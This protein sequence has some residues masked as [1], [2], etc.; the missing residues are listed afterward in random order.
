MKT[1]WIG[2]A[3]FKVE[4]NGYSVVIDPYKP[5]SVPGL[6]AINETADAVLLSHHHGDHDGAEC[7]K[8]VKSGAPEMKVT[9]L[10][11]YHDHHKGSKRGLN[12]M[13]ILEIDGIKVAHLGDL[14]CALTEEEAKALSG[15]DLLMI[16]VG[17][18]FTIDAAEAAGIVKQLAP[19]HVIPMHF[20][21]DA[22]GIGYDVIGPVEEFTKQF[23]KVAVTK[24][25]V[26][27]LDAM[28]EAQ[29]I[30]LTPANCE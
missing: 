22:K 8:L 2:H 21:N 14:G 27:D 20:R 11:T 9:K 16:P 30:V 23:D 6:S 3:C 12:D 24:S 4:H 10:P 19:K 7:V 13:F 17:G 5:G 28:P 25:S 18:F 29:I 15:L 1:T 26:A